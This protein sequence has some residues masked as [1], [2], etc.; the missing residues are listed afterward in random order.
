MILMSLLKVTDEGGVRTIALNRPEKK[1]ALTPDMMEELIVTFRDVNLS[2]ARVLVL[3]GEGAAFC[4]G[5]DI[6]ELQTSL[7]K[8]PEQH[9]V[10]AE[11]VARMFRA[12]WECDVPTI[13][14]VRGPAIAGGT[15]LATV[16]DFTI[17]AEDAK[18]GYT[19]ARIGFVPAVVSAYLSLELGDKTARSLLLTA[20][21]FG[22]AEALRLGLVS[23]VVAPDAVMDRARELAREL[24]ANSPE[25]LRATKR[26]MREQVCDQLEAALAIGMQANAA[27]RETA[28]FRE[29]VTAFLEKR[30]PSWVPQQ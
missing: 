1:N 27:S 18:F 29:G 22:A 23:E 20:R 8:S 24:M 14:A 17:A 19:E 16:C 21:I 9:T 10:D 13:A 25:S 2:G 15:G 5:L 7:G 28:D 26:M 6:G 4:A 11:R 12:L 3:T 30:K